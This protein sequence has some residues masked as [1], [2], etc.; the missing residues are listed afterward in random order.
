MARPPLRQ[1]P[2][3]LLP[4]RC[5]LRGDRMAGAGCPAAGRDLPAG[6]RRRHRQGHLASP[7]HRLRHRRADQR[8]LP[9]TARPDRPGAHPC[10][11]GRPRQ[12]AQGPHRRRRS[13]HVQGDGRQ[14]R[15]LLPAH[16]PPALHRRRRHHHL[17]G[18]DQPH[19]VDLGPAAKLSA[20][21]TW[22]WPAATR[23][24][25]PCFP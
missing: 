2:G 7:A 14:C 5:A 6:C 9:R 1:G 10:G 25:A 19:P 12:G 16:R 13:R 3:A 4:E 11:R 23:C 21:P 20:P 18:E 24:A 15:R 8:L 17:C 22:R